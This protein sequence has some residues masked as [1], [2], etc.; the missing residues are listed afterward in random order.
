M[1]TEPLID[2]YGNHIMHRVLQTDTVNNLSRIINSVKP[3]STLLRVVH[4]H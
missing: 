1:R 4:L 2:R 3:H